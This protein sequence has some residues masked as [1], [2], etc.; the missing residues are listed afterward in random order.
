MNMAAMRQNRDCTDLHFGRLMLVLLALFLGGVLPVSAQD[1]PQGKVDPPV[2][3]FGY[4]PQKCEV[5]HLFYL[6]NVGTAPLTVSRVRAVCSCTSV[7]SIHEPIAPGDSAA[8]LV[9]FRSGR[10]RGRVKKPN[11]V[12]SDDPEEPARL[13]SIVANVVENDEP[14]GEVAVEPRKIEW[15]IV[16]GILAVDTDTL[17]IV[18]NASDALTASILDFPDTIITAIDLPGSIA[19]GDTSEVVLHV[20]GE[21]GL[22][23]LK[24]PSITFAFAA[25]DTTI[26]TIPIEIGD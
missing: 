7:S 17:T 1:F 23:K 13:M 4:L 15:K 16:D 21:P 12:H 20:S 22:S 11:Y 3:D 10:Y 8:I 24:G 9:V 14:T 6:H 26:I 2:W 5:S 18:N 25:Q 19:P